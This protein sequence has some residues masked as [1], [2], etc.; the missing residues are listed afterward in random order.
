MGSLLETDVAA[1]TDVLA[2][3]LPQ[4]LLTAWGY[5]TQGVLQ[6]L[7]LPGVVLVTGEV[8]QLGSSGTASE[9]L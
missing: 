3:V 6:Q 8:P 1:V 4:L 7:Q 5:T 9:W 2:A